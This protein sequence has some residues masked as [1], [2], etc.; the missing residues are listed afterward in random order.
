MAPSAAFLGMMGANALYSGISGYRAGTYAGNIADYNAEVARVRAEDARRAAAI[1][2]GQAKNVNKRIIGSQRAAFGASGFAM[3]GSP[4]NV[5]LSS[6]LQGEYNALLKKHSMLSEAT[7]LESQA[8]IYEEQGRL[9]RQKRFSSILT[10][11]F[12]L[13]TDVFGYY[14]LKE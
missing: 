3:E 4:M 14:A 13:G 8:D 5:M 12:D 11:A 9:A 6:A 1:E 2:Y 10:S 7:A